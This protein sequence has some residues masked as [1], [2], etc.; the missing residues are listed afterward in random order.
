VFLVA[1]GCAVAEVRI[2]VPAICGLPTSHGG[3]QGKDVAQSP[4]P[5]SESPTKL[6]SS[7]VPSRDQRSIKG[8]IGQ[9][10]ALKGSQMSKRAL[11]GPDK[12]RSGPIVRCRVLSGPMGFGPG[13]GSRPGSGTESWP[14][15]GSRNVPGQGPGPGAGQ[16]LGPG[17]GHC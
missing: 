13:T 10:S 1:L 4:R 16:G 14:R 2:A 7:L 6:Q 11:P 17:P 5:C 9:H 15:S 8:L 3:R 12:A